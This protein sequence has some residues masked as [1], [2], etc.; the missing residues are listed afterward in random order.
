LSILA[1]ATL[2]GAAQPASAGSEIPFDREI[3]FEVATLYLELNDTDGDLGIHSL[4]DGDAWKRLQIEDPNGRTI[5]NIGVIGR[6]RAQGLTELFFESAEPPFDELP[7][8][9]F[10]QRFPEGNYEIDGLTLD[11]EER[12]S[13]VI[14]SHVLPAPVANFRISGVPVPENCD[15]VPLPA[16][17][18]PLI[19]TWD[20]VSQS[21]PD[22]GKPGPIQ[23]EHYEAIV[24]RQGANPFKQTVVLPPTITSLEVQNALTNPGDRIKAEVLVR[25]T[26]GNQVALETCVVVAR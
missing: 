15:V 21:H 1:A 6:L 24:E 2:P 5:L 18:E 13:T 19:I 4:I 14:L 3:P 17:S 9:E 25:A 23:V 8:E 16:V 7:P 20:P 10:F 22:I 12:E 11:G 26:S